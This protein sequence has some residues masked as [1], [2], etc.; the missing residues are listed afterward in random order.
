MVAK[1]DGSPQG[2][3]ERVIP[4]KPLPEGINRFLEELVQFASR[5]LPYRNDVGF[6]LARAKQLG[7]MQSFED[8]IFVSKFVSKSIEVM[9]RIGPNGDGY[10]KLATEFNENAERARTLARA[11]LDQGDDLEKRRF[12]DEYFGND[13]ESFARFLG[14]LGDLGWVKNWR[15]DGKPLP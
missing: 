15:V 12:D 7:D 4:V 3:E 8:L 5:E 6:L 11:L 2:K 1:A 14:L 10:Q 9:R 13:Q